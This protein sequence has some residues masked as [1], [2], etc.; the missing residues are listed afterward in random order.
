MTLNPLG[1][2]R[3]AR[4]MWARDRAVLAPLSGLFLFVPQWAVLMLVPEAPALGDGADRAAAVGAWTEAFS[5][6][7][8][9]NAPTYLIAAL[10][11]QFGTLAVAT[12]YLGAGAGQAGSAM[13][14]ALAL[15]GRYLLAALMVWMPLALVATLLLS[16]GGAGLATVVAPVLY[17]LALSVLMLV[18]PAI[19]AGPGSAARAVARSW[20][21][22][23]G[24]RA[25]LVGL[26]GGV[27][28]VSQVGAAVM[29][30]ASHSLKAGGAG[31][32]V[33]LALLDAGAAG[34][35]WA[36]SLTLALAGVAA[37]RVLAR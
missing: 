22:G 9:A 23:R 12:L 10:L 21:L 7:A 35:L 34:M 20:T 31:N 15:Y 16:A 5:A 36:A 30:A 18:A 17:V 2:L 1:L 37:Y 4:A 11:A 13:R 8:S 24:H 14:R 33:A 25:T 28:I 19:A 26:A 3:A 6:W 27:V 29:L 32:P